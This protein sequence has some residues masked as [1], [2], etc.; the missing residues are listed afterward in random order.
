[1]FCPKCGYR[2][3]AKICPNCGFDDSTEPESKENDRHS[4]ILMYTRH[5][6]S[7]NIMMCTIV[8]VPCLL[9]LCPVFFLA[10]ESKI[11]GTLLKTAILIAIVGIALSVLLDLGNTRVENTSCNNQHKPD[12]KKINNTEKIFDG[13]IEFPSIKNNQNLYKVYNNVDICVI[14]SRPPNYDDLKLGEKLTFEQEPTNP[15]DINAVAIYQNGKRLGYLYRGTGQ[16][17]TNDFLRR[18]DFVEGVLTYIKADE[19]TLKMDVAYYK[20]VKQPL[21]HQFKGS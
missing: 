21:C 12:S 11:A 2:H 7:I 16:D 6:L 19:D 5:K 1:M 15:H 10:G 18:G 17:M 8:A 4:N 13:H 20:K 3:G 9:V 14:T